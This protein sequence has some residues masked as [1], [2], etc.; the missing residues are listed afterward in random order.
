MPQIRKWA[1]LSGLV[2]TVATAFL[3]VLNATKAGEPYWFATR[4]YVAAEIKTSVD[5]TNAAVKNMELRQINTLMAIAQSNRARIENEIA[6]KEVLIKQNL[7]MPIEVRSAIEEQTR[8]LRRELEA[9]IIDI[10][11]LDDEQVGVG[12]R[13]VRSPSQIR[14]TR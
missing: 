3:A 9:A 1:A 7:N 11:N 8:G 6:N 14:L 12:Q 10:R 13:P 2:G 5:T 4:G